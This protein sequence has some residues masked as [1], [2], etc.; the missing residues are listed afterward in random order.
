[1]QFMGNIL[2]LLAF[3]WMTRFSELERGTFWDLTAPMVPPA[4]ERRVLNAMLSS[5]QACTTY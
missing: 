5:T 2:H 3:E 4:L 1:M